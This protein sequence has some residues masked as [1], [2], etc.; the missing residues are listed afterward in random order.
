MVETLSAAAVPMRLSD[1][2]Q[3]LDLPKGATHRLLRELSGLGW[4]ERDGAEGPYRLA[5]RFGLLGNRVLQ[6][7]RLSDLT[8]PVLGR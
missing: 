6:A 7:S 4:A 8:Q 3:E 5:L 2:A 1:I